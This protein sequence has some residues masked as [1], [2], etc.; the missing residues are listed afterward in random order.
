MGFGQAWAFADREATVV[1]GADPADAAREQFAD[2]FAA[3]AY[4]D[5]A[6]ML[7]VEDLDAVNVTTPHTL[8]YE[9]VRAALESGAHVHVEKPMVTD[10]GHA[11]ELVD[12]AD[13]RDLVLQVGY[14]RHFDPRYREV[15]RFV[16]SGRLGTIHSAACYLEQA[17]REKVAGTWRTDPSLSGGG[18]LYDSGSHLLDALLWLVDG[19]PR[20][21]AAV[22]DDRG[23][24]VDMNSALAAV[25]ETPDGPVTAS[26]G[27]TGEGSSTPDVGEHLALFGT[28]GSVRFDG[29]ELTVTVG[30]EVAYSADVGDD[31]DF[32][33]LRNSKVENFL[34]AVRGEAEPAVPGEFGLQVVALTEAAYRAAETGRT[35]EIEEL[36][37]EAKPA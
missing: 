3:A 26:V 24:D 10:L 37:A 27:V 36:P 5:V 8:H 4:D 16:E 20:R 1:A 21:V 30:S 31:A 15:R 34:A 35:V 32:G 28:D 29:E 13:E 33:S 18:Q 14:Q 22:M 17:W 6:E 9:H 7:A 2:A 12:L 23:T 25:L 19:E 11:R